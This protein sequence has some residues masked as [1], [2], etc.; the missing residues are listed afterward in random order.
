MTGHQGS[1][2]R[3][4]QRLTNVATYDF[5]KVVLQKWQAGLRGDQDFWIERKIRIASGMNHWTKNHS[6]DEVVAAYAWR[7]E[8]RPRE[9]WESRPVMAVTW[10]PST[11]EAKTGASWGKLTINPTQTLRSW[12]FR[13]KP[14]L[15]R[16]SGEQLRLICMQYQLQAST[17]THPDTYRSVYIRMNMHASVHIHTADTHR[18]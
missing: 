9:P 6:E 13:R 8:F 10:N 15:S 16:Q 1:S 11:R 7:L 2:L 5:I 17:C 14:C 12:G 4:W 18:Q 3:R